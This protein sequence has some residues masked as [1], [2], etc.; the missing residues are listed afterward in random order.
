MINPTDILNT[1]LLHFDQL[2]KDIQKIM[3]SRRMDIDVQK[4]DHFD[5]PCCNCC[6]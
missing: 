5:I 2:P 6:R 3:D 4:D 1:Q